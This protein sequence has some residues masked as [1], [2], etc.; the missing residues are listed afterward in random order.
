L[1]LISSTFKQLFWLCCYFG[2]NARKKINKGSGS[3]NASTYLHSRCRFEF[4]TSVLSK[5]VVITSGEK[6]GSL[7]TNVSHIEVRLQNKS[8]NQVGL[9]ER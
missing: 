5:D 3:I 8:A 7:R 9:D 6:R 4:R 1:S 2:N